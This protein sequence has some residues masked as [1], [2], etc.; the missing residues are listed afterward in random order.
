MTK[1]IDRILELLEG[2]SETGDRQ[3]M[4]KCPSHTDDK[5]SLSLRE[6]DDGTA[7]LNCFADCATTD[8]VDVLGMTMADLFATRPKGSQYVYTDEVGE[9]L[10]RVR[11]SATKE[12]PQSRWDGSAFVSG[13][14]DV[15]RVPY[16][17]PE[18]LAGVASG[19]TIFCVEGEKD[20][21]RLRSHGLVATTNSGGVG[22]GG[23]WTEWGSFFDGARVVLVPDRDHAGEDHMRKVANILMN[24]AAEIRTVMLPVGVKGDVSDYLDWHTIEDFWRLVEDAPLATQTTASTTSEEEYFAESMYL[25]R[26]ERL[27]AFTSWEPLSP[28]LIRSIAEGEILRPEPSIWK[29]DDGACLLYPGRTHIFM[30]ETESLK[31]WAAM[32]V[33]YQEIK[34]GCAV[35]YADLEDEPITSIE[36]LRQLGLTPDEI[37]EGFLYIQ[38]HEGFDDV[39]REHLD[40]RIQMC[41]R[42]VRL[43][44]IDS[45]TEAMALEGLD[46]NVGVAVADFYHLAPL[47]FATNGIAVVIID[48]VTKSHEDRGRWAIGS[49]RKISGLTG[50]A[51]SFNKVREFGRGMT[52]SVK[53]SISKDRPGALRPMASKGKVLGTMTFAS[54][55]ETGAV[56]IDFASGNIIDMAA[57]AAKYEDEDNQ[58]RRDMWEAIDKDPDIT[59]GKLRESVPGNNDRKGS[60]RTWLIDNGFVGVRK[61]AKNAQLHHILK[62]LPPS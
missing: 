54:D 26:E 36:R 58:M 50:A 11:R 35:I 22:G 62:P 38:P 32:H 43:A 25:E 15:R 24:N 53:V 30:G 41:T 52:G 56:T 7:L 2:V 55:P 18:L 57:E 28:D 59:S 44:V 42:A 12:F 23:A 60:N 49:E 17:L 29:R 4:A 6:T 61:G 8:I 33:I 21:E 19:E 3:W 40:A 51:F 45:M 5:A 16:R 10:Y 37:T 34:A 48:H 47:Y 14:G 1:P 27:Q 9:P 13:M 31:S 46:P 20:A 39:A